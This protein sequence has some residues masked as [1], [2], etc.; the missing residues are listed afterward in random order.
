MV[1]HVTISPGAF[2]LRRLVGSPVLQY[3]HADEFR[4]RP[5]LTARAVRRADAVVAVSGYGRRMALDAGGAEERIEVVPPG[6]DVPDR[7]AKRD[8]VPTIVTVARLVAH[9]GHETMVRAMPTVLERVAEARW[10]VV[11][12][13][14]DLAALRD[15]AGSLGVER[16]IV[17]AGPL[18]DAERDEWL[19]RGWV[20][21]MPSRIPPEGIGG[22]G[23]GIVYLEAGAHGLPVVGPNAGG[24]P[25]AV[26]DGVTGVLVDPMD[27]RAVGGAIAGLLLDRERAEVLGAAGRARAEELSWA[28]HASRTREILERLVAGAR[29]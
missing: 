12:E 28:R 3:V 9:K 20:F 13:G 26:L 1:A 29:R 27:P 24:V 10:V 7:R 17:F 6:V 16:A 25:D 4:G 11:G 15:L 5:G 14:P 23:F 21:A 2:A 22:E 18:E 8:P 19:D